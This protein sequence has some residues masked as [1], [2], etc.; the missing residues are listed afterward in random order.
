[1][2]TI[3]DTV[4]FSTE[5]F[6]I[7]RRDV[8]VPKG[9]LRRVLW[10]NPGPYE[11]SSPLNPKIIQKLVKVSNTFVDSC[12]HMSEDAEFLE[13][14][15]GKFDIG[16]VEQYDSCGFG[17]F[18]KLGINSTIWLS[19]TALYRPQ[20][21]NIGVNLPYSYVPELFAQFS[22]EMTFLQKFVNI[23]IGQTTS[24]LL[25]NFVQ[26]R[27]SKIFGFDLSETIQQTS[28]VLVNS[29]PFFDFS[30]P[31]SQQFSNIAGFTVDKNPP[32]LDFYWQKIADV[33]SFILVSF[34]GI[35]R[36]CDMSIE[37]Q[38]IFF[39]SFSKFPN[40]T[41]I[42]KYEVEPNFDIPNNVILT[43]WI[44]QLPLMAHKNY[45]SIITHGGWSTILET[46]IFSK[47]M[48]LMPLFADHAK[49]SKVAESKQIAVLLDKMN[50]S[51]S[52]VVKAI[53]LVLEDSKFA[54]NCQKFSKMFCD[55]PISHEEMIN[56]R[57]RRAMKPH[58][59]KFL[60]PKE[61][62]F[63]FL[64]CSTLFIVILFIYSKLKNINIH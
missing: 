64:Q 58:S 25:E 14:L 19:A 9:Y 26:S 11:D 49:N 54:E 12:H 10:S 51:V 43:P 31:T 44:P 33:Q 22:D 38:Q 6:E 1:M 61:P 53:E 60:K 52:K 3:D 57:I 5:K 15:R 35:A 23:L 17:I 41:F 39:D 18:K 8:G 59:E 40:I 34:G 20:A 21:N 62:K 46:T 30:M 56:W 47:P 32:K 28:S 24:I 50:L 63:E 4:N 55:L 29:A 36:T 37:M 48:I 16:L 7:Y 2:P 45:R 42:V 13:S 27:Q